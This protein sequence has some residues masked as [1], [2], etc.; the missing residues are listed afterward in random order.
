M[1]VKTYFR[2]DL[3]TGITEQ[4]A[5]TEF[6]FAEAR[7]LPTPK[8]GLAVSDALLLVNRWNANYDKRKFW[9]EY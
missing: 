2:Q 7:A 4:L 8:Y 3:E 9:I 1:K 6:D 5:F